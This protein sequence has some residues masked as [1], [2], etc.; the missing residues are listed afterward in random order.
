MLPGH[1]RL[2][3]RRWDFMPLLGV[4]S[5]AHWGDHVA[6]VQ[7]VSG[8]AWSRRV[9]SVCSQYNAT[10][11]GEPSAEPL[12][13]SPAGRYA[14]RCSGLI[15]SPDLITERVRE[16]VDRVLH[17]HN[18]EAGALSDAASGERLIAQIIV[19][20]VSRL[21]RARQTG[22]GVRSESIGPVWPVLD[23]RTPGPVEADR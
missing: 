19:C 2:V 5:T 23:D 10:A 13:F 9:G 3:E 16:L 12:G 4:R 18:N 22:S 15:A 11:F 17:A 7:R 1:D 21:L 8:R 14:C 6:A 20:S